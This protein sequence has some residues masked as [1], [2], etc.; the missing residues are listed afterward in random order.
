MQFMKRANARAGIAVLA[1]GAVLVFSAMAQQQAGGQAKKDVP[2]LRTTSRLVLVSA[3]VQDRRG[4][5]VSGLTQDDF[6]VLDDGKP[7]AISTF[8]AVVSE[9]APNARAAAAPTAP[10]PRNTFSNRE[11]RASGLTPVVTVILLDMLNTAVRDS[12]Y[13][14]QQIV[15]FLQQLQPQDRVAL[16]VLSSRGVRVLLDFTSDPEP[17]LRA[18]TRYRTKEE[19]QISASDPE[20]TKSGNRELDDFM[21]DT[22]RLEQNFV[23]RDRVRRTVDALVA[24]SNHLISVPGRK[25]LVW[26]SGSFPISFG[27]DKLY[28]STQDSNAID[29]SSGTAIAALARGPDSS[30]A[31]VIRP[32]PPTVLPTGNP[33]L[34][35]APE[36]EVFWRDLERAARALNQANLAIYPVDA[37]GL[38]T[39]APNPNFNPAAVNKGQGPAAPQY[40]VGGPDRK[41]FD[42]MNVLADR[43]GGRAFYNQNDIHVSVREAIDESSVTYELGYYPVHNT[44]DGKFHEITVR[45]K[46]SGMH[47]RHRRGYFAVA[48]APAE[49]TKQAELLHAAAESP[50]ESAALGVQVRLERVPGGDARTLNLRIALETRE[51]SLAHEGER[52]VG[53]LA[54]L[55]AQRKSSGESTFGAAQTVDLKLVQATYEKLMREGIRLTK[56][57][58]LEPDAEELRVVVRDN[59]SGAT[60]TVYIPLDR[61]RGELK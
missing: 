58:Q 56:Q 18:L 39:T 14:Q 50:L 54:V 48:D 21:K 37:R 12:V 40:T 43:T 16:Y 13:G 19:G 4:R 32:T 9:R 8:A 31:P 55:V 46:R 10:Q 22:S 53:A 25:N 57:I 51:V 52:W 26:V 17:L 35:V 45:L 44:W 47:A 38:M 28:E 6:V 33:D 20:L 1:A 60:G 11:N 59:S 2:V 29:T 24:I 34:L 27:F 5:P 15:R 42:S 41:E 30:S 3:I 23:V 36:Q 49:T 61:F 7:Q